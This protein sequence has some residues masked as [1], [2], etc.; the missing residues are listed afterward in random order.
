MAGRA[1]G[2]AVSNAS[3]VLCSQQLDRVAVTFTCGDATNACSIILKDQD[4][5]TATNGVPLTFSSGPL[6]V[7]GSSARHRWSAIRLAAVDCVVGVIEEYPDGVV[8][9]PDADGVPV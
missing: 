9:A 6:R 5:A 8:K 3:V 1:R 7:E 4:D 2:V